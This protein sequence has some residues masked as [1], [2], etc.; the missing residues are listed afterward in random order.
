MAVTVGPYTRILTAV[1]LLAASC[2]MTG[3]SSDPP[4]PPD[5]SPGLARELIAQKW[6]QE[7][8]NHYR[9]TFHSDTLI[10]CGVANGLWTLEEVK[11]ASGNPWSKIYRLTDKGSQVVH[12]I[13]LRDSG[14]GHQVVLRGPYQAEVTS[15][16]EGA[17]P[18]QK[19]V[20]FKWSIDWDKAAADLKACL[21]RF[22][23][24]GN[25][26]AQFEL[27]DNVTWRFAAYLNP[28]DAPPPAQA[29]IPGVR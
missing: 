8:L 18:P 1:T 29:S 21:P 4:P 17:Q 9:V 20:A 6:A 14:R 15:V 10:E 25:E 28:A 23:L 16:S 26:L 13:D 7:E 24:T 11:D 3:C 12:S 5:L 2:A 19:R 27:V 22:E